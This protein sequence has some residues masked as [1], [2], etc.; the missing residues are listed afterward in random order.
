MV[1]QRCRTTE[2]PVNGDWIAVSEEYGKE[3]VCGGIN[4]CA[5]ACGSIYDILAYENQNNK[6]STTID[7]W[8]DTK[9]PGLNYGFTNFDNILW[10]L[11]TIF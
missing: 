7:P 8:R 6:L 9:V 3:L 10:A 4:T 11:L 2:F 1:H 5:I